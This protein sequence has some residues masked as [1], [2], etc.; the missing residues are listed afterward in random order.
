MNETGRDFVFHRPAMRAVS[1]D[2]RRGM[3][4]RPLS[5]VAAAALAVV[6]LDGHAGWPPAVY[7]LGAIGP[8][9][10]EIIDGPGL[11][12][13]AG[14][15][16]AGGCDVN[17]DGIPDIV[18]GAPQAG[19]PG[20][21]EVYVVYGNASGAP[22]PASV[23]DADVA[24]VGENDGDGLGSAMACADFNGDGFDD[25]LMTAP[26]YSPAGYAYV[27]YGGASLPNTIDLAALG[28][29]QGMRIPGLVSGTFFGTAA[30]AG[31][32]NGDGYADIAVTAPRASGSSSNTGQGFVVFGGPSLPATFDLSTLNGSNGF[33]ISS[34]DLQG[35]TP[36]GDSI[37][38][39]DLNHDG[40]ADVAIG[41]RSAFPNGLSSA[42]E[43]WVVFGKAGGFAPEIQ[44]G[45]LNGGNGFAIEPAETGHFAGT[46]VA[47]V[48][49]FN[50]DGHPDLVIGAPATPSGPRF[51]TAYVVFGATTFPAHF[52]LGN[53][54]GA[55]GVALV[56]PTLSDAAGSSV[57]GLP[58][59][60]GDRLG[61][62]MLGAPS[63]NAGAGGGF[64][65]YG[66][67]LPFPATIDLS[68]LNGSTGFRI[69]GAAAQD[70]AGTAVAYAGDQ[71]RDGLYDLLIAAPFAD[72]NGA[73]NVGAIYVLFGNDLIFA[74]GF[75]G[76]P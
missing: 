8:G 67:R 33:S 68:T 23:N 3:R 1:T 39:G 34:T 32:V 7:D 54:D 15:S 64:V 55:N 46:S 24:I 19:V 48:S 9:T 52:G 18:I 28:G 53:L 50:G 70:A 57:S 51:G 13:H 35:G 27:V 62:V 29:T 69:D 12:A 40:N 20:G 58:D 4:V 38:V 56:S 44:V 47:F 73:V 26:G 22:L 25:L 76:T 36:N 16:M 71:N 41:S 43:V 75:D 65:V 30:A 60:N 74:D 61:E 14:M 2:A 72:V 11:A 17:G 59:L 66:R 63:A 21:G 6:A 37:A 45:T 31:D 42:G 10:G 49:D 5:L